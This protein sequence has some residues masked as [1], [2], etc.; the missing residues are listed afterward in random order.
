MRLSAAP[1]QGTPG[2]LVEVAD[3]GPGVAADERAQIFERF[4]RSDRARQGEG[5]GLGLAIARWIVDEHHGAL[6]VE[7]T[8]DRGATFGLWLPSTSAPRRHPSFI[9]FFIE[10]VR[11]AP[12]AAATVP[13]LR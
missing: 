13:A 3:E 5:A 12:T 6:D 11:R 1:R 2:A 9:E 4:Y 10:F 7:S 8:S